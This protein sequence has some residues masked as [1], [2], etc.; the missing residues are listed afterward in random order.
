[1]A[2]FA[3]YRFAG[4]AAALLV[5]CS[6]SA[7]MADPVEDFYK[8]RTVTIN[9]GYTAGGGYD[10]YAR[11]LAQFIGKHIPGNPSI[12]V[13]NVPGAS[14][15]KLANQMFAIA[16]KDGSEIATIARGAPVHD[17]LGGSGMRFDPVKFN[18][19]GSMNNEISVCVSSYRSP[20]KTFAD[21]QKTELVVG[22][23]GK[24]S[25]SEVFAMFVKNLFG[26]KVKLISG[27]PGTK[28]SILAMERGEVDGNCGWSWTS[29]K[30]M[31]SDW[32]KEGK[33]NILMQQALSKH[34]DLPNVPL[35][36]EFAKTDAEKAQIELVM[37]R[38]T[39]GRPFLAPP[40]VPADRVAALRK[41]FMATMSDPQFK[42]FADKS[43][44]EVNPVPG[45]EVQALVE[46]VRKTPAEVVAM[47]RE[48]I[49]HTGTIGTAPA[50]KPKQ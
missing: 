14:S 11:A 29:A 31:K 8:G 35:I 34:P 15:L 37:S 1:M 38:Q 16:P 46:R 30:Q 10:V 25:D 21:L 5:T 32:I 33:L 6:A 24:S 45:E 18:W 19:L 23:Q 2:E 44:L 50:A 47:A 39:M 7:A 22:G 48:N 9:V 43:K 49:K 3:R 41:A 42:A 13:K 26:A 28:E 40:D 36:T 27:Y 4:V 17:M 20:I 12:V